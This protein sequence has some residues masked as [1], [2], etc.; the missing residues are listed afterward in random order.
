MRIHK[1]TL[2]LEDRPTPHAAYSGCGPNVCICQLACGERSN[3]NLW[4]LLSV[5]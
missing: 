5:L 2:R 1:E 4:C 3:D